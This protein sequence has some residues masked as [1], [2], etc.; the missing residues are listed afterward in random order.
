MWFRHLSL[1]IWDFMLIGI[2]GH[3]LEENRT[4]VG[5]FLWNILKEWEKSDTDDYQFILYFKNSVPKDLSFFWY[6]KSKILKAPLGIKSNFL[7]MQWLLPKA[8]KKDRV[9]ILFCPAYIKPIFYK[10]K[11]AVIIHDIIYQAHPE[12][13]NWNSFLEK[14]IYKSIFKLSA[15]KADLIFT[16]S[17]FSK[18]EIIKY[19]KITENE[20][21]VIPLGVDN[22]FLYQSAIKDEKISEI[23]NKYKIKDKFI[24]YV[25]SIFSRRHVPELLAAFEDILRLKPDY[26]LLLGGKN[27][28][29]PF[30][31]IDGLIKQ[32]NQKLNKKAIIHIDYIETKDLVWL[33]KLCDLFVWL[34]DYEGFGL[35][36]LEALAC[37]AIVVTSKKGSIPEIVDDAVI[38]IKNNKN[39]QEIIQALI[40]GLNDNK[41][42]EN[43]KAKSKTVIN[44]FSWQM[45]AWTIL[46]KI[47]QL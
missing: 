26:Q 17:N 41:L 7:F 8:A 9:D 11:T 21:T 20:I 1:K 44:K 23:K 4:G 46:E 27:Y 47:N 35:P 14:I 32:I 5:R 39:P 19:Y 43:L 13:Y 15:K 16:P 22:E 45:S 40:K 6:S 28:T 12:W 34:S 2:D 36:P 42:R 29:K 10:I 31:D 25:G 24:F 18:K 30:I 3:N 37:G 38:Y 33:Y